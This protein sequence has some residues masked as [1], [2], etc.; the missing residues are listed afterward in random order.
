MLISRNTLTVFFRNKCLECV[1]CWRELLRAFRMIS[2]DFSSF[3]SRISGLLETEDRA[4]LWV[5]G[6]LGSNKVSGL[7]LI[8]W[9]MKSQLPGKSMS[10]REHIIV[11]SLWFSLHLL[12][13]IWNRLC[14]IVRWGISLDKMQ[15][16]QKI[17]CFPRL[18]KSQPAP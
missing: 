11:T 13:T 12:I 7:V 14:V 8:S 6:L 2:W 5:S 1:Y 17:S 4:L 3:S 15:G 18:R 16:F 9:R 10:D